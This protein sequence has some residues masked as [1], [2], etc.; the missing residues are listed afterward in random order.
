LLLDQQCRNNA[1]PGSV[2][3]N[4]VAAAIASDKCN[5]VSTIFGAVGDTE[6]LIQQNE[7]DK[8][9][10]QSYTCVKVTPNTPNYKGVVDIN[11]SNIVPLKAVDATGAVTDFDSIVVRWFTRKDIDAAKSTMDIGFPSSG[12]SVILPRAGSQW[13]AN[14]PSLLRTQ[15]MQT[16]SSFKLSDFDDNQAGSKSNASTFF[17]YPSATGLTSM[18]FDSDARRDPLN[19]PRLDKCL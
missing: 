17:L 15:F 16:G 12:P 10:Q 11:Q 13:R 18:S 5:T 9:L 7:G 19:T 2:N 14:Y 6:T 3:C 8:A 4:A 1:A